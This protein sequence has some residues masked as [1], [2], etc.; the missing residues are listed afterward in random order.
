[1]NQ[2][3]YQ[4]SSSESALYSKQC[5]LTLKCLRLAY[6]R[7]VAAGS[8][9]TVPA[10]RQCSHQQRQLSFSHT[11]TLAIISSQ[12]AFPFRAYT[13]YFRSIESST[14]SI[15]VPAFAPPIVQLIAPPLIELQLRDVSL[16]DCS[17]HTSRTHRLGAGAAA[18]RERIKT[19][20]I[21][22]VWQSE[23]ANN[24]L[25]RSPAQETG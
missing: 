24:A 6:E 22:R 2:L 14:F 5:V 8:P 21:P 13:L 12:G 10:T 20:H 19:Q 18:L 16:R 25:S 17:V 11:T 15:S 4:I 9:A 7:S 23:E 1:M 3:L